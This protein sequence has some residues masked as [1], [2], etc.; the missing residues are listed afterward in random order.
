[1]Y[2]LIYSYLVIFIL[3]SKNFFILNKNYLIFSL[4]SDKLKPV[5]FSIILTFSSVTLLYPKYDLIL[6][7]LKSL[8]CAYNGHPLLTLFINSSVDL[9]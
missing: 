9:Q 4:Y 5:E 6:A 2:L 3:R 7:N 1:M 8:S